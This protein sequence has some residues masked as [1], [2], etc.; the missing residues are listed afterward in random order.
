[1]SKEQLVELLQEELDNDSDLSARRDRQF[2]TAKKG[3]SVFAQNVGGPV[4]EYLDTIYAERVKELAK[5]SS[6]DANTTEERIKKLED[7]IEEL[8]K[9]ESR[10]KKLE[11]KVEALQKKVK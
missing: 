5:K 2:K 10:I 8:N 6:G 1:M 3:N 9:F 4:F 7:K 11:D